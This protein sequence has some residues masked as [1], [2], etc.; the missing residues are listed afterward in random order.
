MG[1]RSFPQFYRLFFRGV[2]VGVV[3]FQGGLQLG[4]LQLA[5]VLL[6]VEHPVDIAVHDLAGHLGNEPEAEDQHQEKTQ[7]HAQ[8]HHTP[9]QHLHDGGSQCVGQK[10]DHAVDAVFQGQ[11]QRLRKRFALSR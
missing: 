1:H 4:I 11:A 6:D 3:L 10:G 5:D 9:E 8:D 7:R 2:V